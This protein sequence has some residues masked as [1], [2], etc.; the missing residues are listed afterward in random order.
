[1]HKSEIP[2]PALVIDLDLLKGNIATMQG[3]FDG[4][5]ARLRP[6]SKTHKCP[7]IARMQVE[8]GAL[9]ITCAKLGEARVMVEAGLSGIL[10]ANQVIGPAK[11]RELARLCG[12]AEVIAA[13]D[14]PE[15]IAELAAAAR[16]EGTQI[17]LIVEVDV[18]MRRAGS[19]SVEQ[20]VA[21]AERIARTTGLQFRGLM[22]YEGH[23]VFIEPFAERRSAGETAN[24]LLVQHAEGVRAAGLP[25]GIVSG[26]GTGTYN[27]CGAYPG[28]TEVQAGSYP[29]MD[30][31]YHALLPEFSPAMTLLTTVVSRPER[32][33]AILDAGLKSVTKEFGLPQPYRFRGAELTKLSEEHAILE[34]P[35]PE[36]ELKV[37]EQL[38]LLPT[39]GCTTINLHDRFYVLQGEEVAAT[40]AVAGRGKSQ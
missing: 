37:G 36:R 26:G 31:R 3:F 22:G 8:A 9:G 34:L 6:H 28:I 16:A 2:T 5:P 12:R 39:H 18:G 30:A 14:N 4:R 24:A 29:T 40:W 38:E 33:R 1:V 25:V 21:L 19:R 10:I 35:D 27:I 11:A 13:A 7:E 15:N 32:G 17:N 23:A 20:T